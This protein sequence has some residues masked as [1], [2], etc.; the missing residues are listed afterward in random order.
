MTEVR[1]GRQTPTNSYVIPYK[2]T[3][4]NEAI[5]IY[6]DT[7]RNAREWQEIQLYD[8]MSVNSDGLWNHMKYGFSVPRRNGK[9]EILVMRELWGLKHNEMILHTAHRTTTSH[10]SW[11]KLC[12]ML[13]EL[14]YE[15]VKRVD[16]NK[17]YEKSYSATAQF[18]LETI[19]LLGEEKG[20]ISFR[21]RSSKGGL[22]EGFDLL[23]IDE[24]QDYTDDQESALQYV[25]TDSDNPQTI[26]CGTPPTAVSSGTVFLKLRNDCLAGSL[27]D[28]GWA[29]W[30]IPKLT[31]DVNNRDIWYETN[32][33]LGC[34]LS[35]RSVANENKSEIIDYN[36]Q[37]FGLWLSYS[38]KSLI[39]EAHWK[40][41]S[42]TPQ[43][44][45]DHIIYDDFF[46]GIKFG[47]DGAN[48][49]LSLA[50]KL[51]DGTVF[52]ETYD[53]RP[54]YQDDAW[55][56]DFL[57]KS[58]VKFLVV[59]GQSKQSILEAELKDARVKVKMIKPTVKQ[60][61]ESSSLFM[62]A[63]TNETIHHAD[64]PSLTQSVSNADK[65]AIGTSGGFGF[66]SLKAD[67]DIS[68]MES[69]VLAHWL[70][71]TKKEKKKQVISY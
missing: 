57:R 16:K 44:A 2:E 32:P 3:L 63:V 67:V 62:Q 23:I 6:N 41:L 27:E 54:Q 48:T 18:G 39:S 35:V 45:H 52:V 64:Q 11:V 56:I 14:G 33:S 9:S 10:A 70:C 4:G 1:K 60:V 26:M 31:E 20:Q 28:T 24:A 69:V 49:A 65:R 36:I 5:D 53:V 17:T 37:R 50:T 12:N 13:D 42:V 8:I 51:D 7:T 30:S 40:S 38:Q 47:N 34:G 59:D 19:T 21:T 55:I 71:S 29:E 68:L 46:C 15:Q 22:G 61:I 58:K 43:Y 25:V 66:K